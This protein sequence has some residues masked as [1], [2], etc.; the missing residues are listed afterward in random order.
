[1]KKFISAE[2]LANIL[3]KKK[4]IV[5][6]SHGVFDLLHHGH[7]RHFE[8]IRNKCDI[9]I[10]S[11]TSDKFVK[12]GSNRPYFNISDRVYALSQ[13]KTVDYIIE[14]KSL[15]AIDVIKKIKPNLYCKGSDYRDLDSD[16]TKKIFLEKKFVEK[17]GGKL[18]FTLAKTSSSSKLINSEFVFNKIQLSFLKK[19]SQKFNITDIEKFFD[20]IAK[21]NIYVF[22]ESIIDTYTELTAL[23]KSGKEA[24]LNFSENRKDNY[25][26]GVL[27]V[28]NN[29]ANF[30]KKVNLTSYV[31]DKNNYLSFINKNLK[32]NIEHFFV[33][34][35]NSP[36]ILKERFIDGYSDKK[37]IGIYNLNDE[38]LDQTSEK[39]I[40]ERI[41][42]IKKD[43]LILIFDYGH[44]FFTKKISSFL[45]SKNNIYKSVN[46][47]LNSS[48]ISSHDIQKFNKSFLIT[49]NETELRHEMRNK[50]LPVKILMKKFSNKTNCKYILITMGKNGSYLYHQKSKKFFFCP[51]FANSI[52][53][54]TGAGDS[55]I[56]IVSVGLKNGLDEELS[57]FL[58]SII[59]AETIKNVANK[60]FMSK[61]NLID[62]AQ[63]MLKI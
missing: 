62:L 48:T 2:K 49:L 16:R 33:K 61:E 30:V 32:Q 51:G 42:K 35:K 9:L 45:N 20:I 4:K 29:I 15:S 34:K 37:I 26:G 60:K 59:A 40:I 14:S 24:I 6:L 52:V 5:A 13:L 46:S 19:L 11:L 31:G 36:T 17:Y 63:T 21:Q 56:P 55:M 3:N 23:N 39:K 10:V 27:A 54:K 57:L 18:L 58:G 50:S 38:S 1:M 43:S 53:D 7:L 41:K 22:G 44:G 25:P 12:K 28:C 47:Q 8:E